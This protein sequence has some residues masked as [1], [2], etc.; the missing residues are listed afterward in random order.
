MLRVALVVTIIHAFDRF[1]IDTDRPA[2]M[3]QGTGIGIILFLRKT[4]TACIVTTVCMFAAHHDITLAAALILVVGTI[5]YAT[6]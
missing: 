2:G 5:V 1:A 4:L 6:F 3:L